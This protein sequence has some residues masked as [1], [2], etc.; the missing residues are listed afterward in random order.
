MGVLKSKG[1]V[2]HVVIN[3]ARKLRVSIEILFE[4]TRPVW[5]QV[6]VRALPFGKSRYNRIDFVALY[7]QSVG[8]RSNTEEK[9]LSILLNVSF[10]F[11]TWK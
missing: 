4:Q 8:D 10:Y 6:L 1:G 7:V 9:W 2:R 11:G 5:R 3:R